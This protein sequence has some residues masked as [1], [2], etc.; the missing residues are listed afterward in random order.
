MLS[1]PVII[2]VNNGSVTYNQENSSLDE[3][4]AGKTGDFHTGYQLKVVNDAGV[5]LP[6]TGG[7]G[8]R[9]FTILGSILLI[10]TGVLLWRRRRMI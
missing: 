2:T 10:G 1:N 6:G 3:S 9:F 7:P 8:T 5:K 4:G